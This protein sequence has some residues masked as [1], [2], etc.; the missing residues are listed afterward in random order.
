[1]KFSKGAIVQSECG[2]VACI[3]RSKLVKNDDVEVDVFEVIFQKDPSK[4]AI[5]AY[6]REEESLD[7]RLLANAPDGA[8]PENIRLVQ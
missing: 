7:A 3:H 2:Q 6:V 1:M 4:R 8:V 5:Y